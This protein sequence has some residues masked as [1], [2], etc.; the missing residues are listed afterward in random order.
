[1]AYV[2]SYYNK[3]AGCSVFSLSGGMELSSSVEEDLVEIRKEI[4][5]VCP[6]KLRLVNGKDSLSISYLPNLIVDERTTQGYRFYQ[7]I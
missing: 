3:K 7:E 1:M 2:S 5:R 6:M 4:D